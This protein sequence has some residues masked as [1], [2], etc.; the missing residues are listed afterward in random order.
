MEAGSLNSSPASACSWLYYS[1]QGAYILPSVPTTEP[2]CEH[3]LGFGLLMGENKVGK[4]KPVV[5][6]TQCV[7]L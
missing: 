6:L 7:F 5:N 2:C 3:E 4:L 1:E